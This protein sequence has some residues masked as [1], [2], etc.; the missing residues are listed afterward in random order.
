VLTFLFPV[1]EPLNGPEVVSLLDGMSMNMCPPAL[2]LA[3]IAAAWSNFYY[4]PF[5]PAETL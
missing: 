5:G 4:E 3:A 1:T 2:A